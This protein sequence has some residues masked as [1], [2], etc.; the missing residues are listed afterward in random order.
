MLATRSG[1]LLLGTKKL[2][3]LVFDGR[4]LEPFHPTLKA[5][6][7]TT[8]AG[9][10]TDF[11]VGTLDA[12][13]YHFHSGQTDHF[14]D[15]DQL[16]DQQILSIAIASDMTY[17]GTPVGIASFVNGKFSRVIA[18]QLFASSL[19]VDGTDLY[20]GTED[21]G[22]FTI[23]LV[24][25]R[26]HTNSAS[27]LTASEI[28]QLLMVDGFI[29]A[30]TREAIFRS[31]PH[32]TAWQKAFHLNP[33]GL[34]DDNI[35][36]LAQDR[37]G[38]LWIGYFDRGLDILSADRSRTRHIEDD[39][40]FCV[41]RILSDAN[42][43]AVDIATANGLVRINSAGSIQQVLTRKNGLIADHVTDVAN[44]GGGLVVA[45]P[46]GLT[47]LDASGVRS[48]YAFQG[49]VNNHVYALGAE[50]D[51]LLA[52]TLGGISQLEK[53]SI[54]RSFTTA[55]SS[56]R[57]N[58]ITAIVRIG[59]E[60]M[61]GTYGDGVVALDRDGT[62]HRFETGSDGY[63]VNP[64]AMV[65]T[66]QHVFAGTLGRGLYVYERGTGRWRAIDYGL[67]SLNVTAIA[68]GDGYIYIGTDNGL[69]RI[70]EQSLHS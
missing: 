49:L 16:P 47:F 42:A 24:S 58:W 29:I 57:R 44:Y 31:A 12:G 53:E 11:W 67:P 27:L 55:T 10:E 40:V 45:T 68:S 8:L 69:V 34:A 36:A 5:L 46:A 6:D 13:L 56:L 51:E 20:I 61:I 32:A 48:L 62:F 26:P 19:L 37:D 9:D 30:V 39:H 52:G 35:S 3:V 64:N 4:S 59:E 33:G 21:Q 18:P 54:A 38:R 17:V 25:S 66:P 41:N 63:E 65:V 2:G 1:R 15:H 23:S 50:G 7:V 22:L 28:H 60:W 14:T 70:R 43:N